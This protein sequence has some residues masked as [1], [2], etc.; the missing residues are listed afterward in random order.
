M[1]INTFDMSLDSVEIDLEFY[2]E[3]KYKFSRTVG[4]VQ[5]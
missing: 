4:D 5:K 1:T 2:E 3:K